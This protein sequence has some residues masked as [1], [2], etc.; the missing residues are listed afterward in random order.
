MPESNE[1]D[2][3]ESPSTR[4]TASAGRG[5]VRK[6][7]ATRED[8]SDEG[9]ELAQT[10]GRGRRTREGERKGE[11]KAL[12]KGKEKGKGKTRAIELF[13]S[14]AII[15]FLLFSFFLWLSVIH[16]S[17]ATVHALCKEI[18]YCSPIPYSLVSR[19]RRHWKRRAASTAVISFDGS[20]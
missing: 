15:S 10:E 17:S 14:T 2:S 12:I 7:V 3:E 5:G 16:F 20:N 19:A 11:T 4:G 1:A 13:T 18:L 6:K 9:G 8:S